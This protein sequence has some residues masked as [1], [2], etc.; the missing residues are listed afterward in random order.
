MLAQNYT[1]KPVLFGCNSSM[2]T[3]GDGTSPIVAYF[4]NSPYS[5][6]SNYSWTAANMSYAEFNG[7]LE[8][9][10]NIVSQGNGTLS[11]AWAECLGCA[12]I[13]R[14]LERMGIQRPEFCE[15]CFQEHCWDGTITNELPKEFVLDPTLA[16]NPD[17]TYA[18]WSAVHP[19]M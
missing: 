8:N 2:T 6:Y 19:D 1:L 5:W 14:S 15:Q 16:L 18:E 4:T 17:L 10:F 3:T 12:A 7:I 9:S 11:N 13:D